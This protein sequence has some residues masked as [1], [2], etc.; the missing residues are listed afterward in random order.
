MPLLRLILGRKQHQ[1]APMD[2]R[3]RA[4]LKGSDPFWALM[5]SVYRR[6]VAMCRRYRSSSPLRLRY[7]PALPKH[8]GGLRLHAEG[9]RG[10]IITPERLAEAVTRILATKAA[11]GLHLGQPALE[12]DEALRVVG[13]E[14]HRAWAR[15]CADSVITL[16]KEENGVIPLTAER[17]PRILCYPIETD[18]GYS[19]YRVV[20]GACQKAFDALEKRGMRSELFEPPRGAEGRPPPAGIRGDRSIRPDSLRHQYGDEKQSDH[21]PHRMGPAHGRQLHA[22]SA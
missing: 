7:V 6:G 2:G 19:Q 1:L 5:N 22:L 17:Y 12:A 20:S 13:C 10:G 15:A 16:V 18:G 3:L 9:V 11:L 14:E 8:G 4:E 21:C